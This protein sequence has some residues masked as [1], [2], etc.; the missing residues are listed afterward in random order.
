MSSFQHTT[1]SSTSHRSYYSTIAVDRHD[2]LSRDTFVSRNPPV[3]RNHLLHCPTL[4]DCC[5]QVVD[6]RSTHA[7]SVTPQP[8]SIPDNTVLRQFHWPVANY[9]PPIHV[10]HRTSASYLQWAMNKIAN[11][12]LYSIDTESDVQTHHYGQSV[13][14]LIQVQAIHHENYSTVFLFEMQH[15]PHRSSSLFLL[16][17]QL[18]QIIFSPTNRLVAW[19]SLA[20]KLFPFEQFS[21]LATSELPNT[22]NLQQYFADQWNLKHPHTLECSARHQP[23]TDNSISGEYLECLVNADDLDSDLIPTLTIDHANTCLCPDDI[24]PYKSQHPI[25]SLQKAIECTFH[26]ALGPPAIL[27]NWSCGLDFHLHN[28][29]SLTEKHVRHTLIS[30]VLSR[31]FAQTNLLFHLQDSSSSF[32]SNHVPMPNEFAITQQN[33]QNELPSFFVLTDSHGRN[34]DPD[35]TTSHYRMRT[36]AISGLQWV[37]PCQRELCATSL[38]LSSSLSPMISSCTSILLLIG[39][40]SVRNTAAVRIIQQVEHVISVIRTNYPH[41]LGKNDIS[42]VYAFPCLKTSY[43]FRSIE[44]LLSNI[45]EYNSLLLEL[46]IRLNFSVVDLHITHNHL[47][48]DGMH[49]HPTCRYLMRGAIENYFA[50]TLEMRLVTTNSRQRSREALTRRNRKRHQR[51]TQQ[52]K[53]HTIVRPIDRSWKLNEVKEYLRHR[54]IKYGRLPE[55]YHH[56]LR[57][58]FNNSTD[59]QHAD[60]TLAP[61]DFNENNYHKWLLQKPL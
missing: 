1:Y 25:W 43:H 49:L 47:N 17:Q 27:H 12:H 51:S 31:L 24:H 58:Q 37:Q 28:W 33:P 44:S 56:Q 50:T 19:G 23:K 13:P 41:F 53:T 15:L 34:L 7:H 38:I 9:G 10:H 26:Q 35:L 21:L 54:E 16:I 55:V 20:E 59:Q 4:S 6:S 8:T 60:Q 18:C 29:L 61:D 36:H 14:S 2:S 11:V 45:D 52:R 57:I 42:L 39:T 40:N 22:L 48:T 5:S 32:S 3:S 30:N 46:S